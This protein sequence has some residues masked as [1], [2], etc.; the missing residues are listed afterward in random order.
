MR[1]VSNDIDILGFINV[2]MYDFKWGSMLAP[3]HHGATF[4]CR[5]YRGGDR[6]PRPFTMTCRI[7]APGLTYYHSNMNITILV[8][9]WKL[10]LQTKFSHRLPD[11]FCQC[12]WISK[13]VTSCTRSAHIATESY[14]CRQNSHIGYLINFV[15][16]HESQKWSPAAHDSPVTN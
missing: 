9:N 5:V 13:M 12:P 15:N 14:H 11:Q 10:S 6:L 1:T 3:R 8:P 2:L 4:H 7:Q 16:V